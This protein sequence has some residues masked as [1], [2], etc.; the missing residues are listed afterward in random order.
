MKTLILLIWSKCFVRAHKGIKMKI[1]LPFWNRL[2]AN[3]IKIIS[4]RTVREQKW[5]Q[6]CLEPIFKE[7]VRQARWI[8]RVYLEWLITLSSSLTNISSECH[9][10]FLL[11]HNT[12]VNPDR[13]FCCAEHGL[14]PHVITFDTVGLAGTAHI[15][16]NKISANILID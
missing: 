5:I 8:C 9:Q 14:Y 13:L 4:F 10:T 2:R 12:L 11:T 15:S 7:V 16:V 3:T 6:Q 1:S